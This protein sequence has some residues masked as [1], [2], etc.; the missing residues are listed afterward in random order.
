MHHTITSVVFFVVLILLSGFA[1]AETCPSLL[2]VSGYD[3]D[4]VHV[5]DGCNGRFRKHLDTA[6]RI[7]GAQGLATD[8]QGRLYVVSEE[9]GRVLRYRSDNL[10]FLDVFAGPD[11]L[12]ALSVKRPTGIAIGPEGDVYVAGYD[13]N[14]VVRLDPESGE[15]IRHYHL[16][17]AGLVGADAGIA[18]LPDGR[19]LVP[20]FDSGN[21]IAL[22]PESGTPTVFLAAGAEGVS[23]PRVVRIHGNENRLLISSWGSNRIHAFNFSGELLGEVLRAPSPTGFIDD[24]DGGWLV[25]SD[26]APRIDAYDQAGIHR[27]EFLAAHGGLS[28]ATFLLRLVNSNLPAD[29][30][31]EFALQDNASDLVSTIS[32]VGKPLDDGTLERRDGR[33]LEQISGTTSHY[34]SVRIEPDVQLRT[35]ITVPNDREG[36]FTPV[37]FTQWVS[38]VSIEHSESGAHQILGSIARETGLALLRVERSGQG[39]SLGPNCNELDYD[40]EVA[41]YISAY[42]QLLKHELIDPGRVF[43]FGMSLGS[44][45][46]PLVA[47]ALQESGFDI[48]GI[49]VQGG[50]ALTHFERMLRFDRIYLERRPDEIK[51]GQIHEEMFDRARFHVEYLIKGRHPDAVA[52][53]DVDMARVRNDI[54]GLAEADHYGRPFAWHQQAARR[55]FLGAWAELEAPVLVIFNEFDQF[56]TRHGHQL[57]VDTV[58]RLRPKTGTLIV[59]QGIGHNHFSYPSTEAAYTM[60]GGEPAWRQTADHLTAWLRA[61]AGTATATEQ[62][63]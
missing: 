32:S 16:S 11:G 62:F 44:T 19:L 22:D 37:L 31:S 25:T 26:A 51:P 5:F 59:Q 45:T 54:F 28:G 50:G 55:D 36:P 21:V 38:C 7:D 17:P 3:S 6:G 48:A 20:G 46:A 2:L 24:A 13:S 8:G 42:K 12:A 60:E 61:R 57:I 23:N 56:E 14:D 29:H 53:D 58:E 41:H 39:D 49:A 1:A 63:G 35:I 9:N 52:N 27:G 47:L 40:T 34:G 15:E 33:P 4:N 10:G 30:R 43:L 18:F